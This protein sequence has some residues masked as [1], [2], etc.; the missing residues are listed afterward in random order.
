MDRGAVEVDD[1]RKGIL[2][3]AFE[4]VIHR[5]VAR[6]AAQR[7]DATAIITAGR[8]ISYAT[9]DAAADAYA[10]E[11]AERGVGPDTVVPLLLPRSAQLIALELGIL[12]CGA[13]YAGL[14]LRWPADR[15]AAIIDLLSPPLV[16]AAEGA[17]HNLGA[18]PVHPVAEEDVADAAARAR[19]F[20]ATAPRSSAPATVFF[21]SGT[22]GRPKIVVS[23][24]QAVS[25]MFRPDGLAGFGPGHATPQAAPLPWDMYAFEVWGQLVS[26]GTTVLV[27][28]DHLMPHTLREL[29][30]TA[31][32]D[33]LWITTS[34]FNLFV[35][36][37]PGC[38]AG[39]RQVLSGGEKLSPAHVRAFLQRHPDIPL[40]NGYGPAE[41]CMLT[42]TRLLRPEDCDLPGGV[43][44]GTAVPGTTV[45]VLDQDNRPCPAGQPGEI[46]IAG[47]G[48]ARGYFGDPELTA[49]KFPDI[50]VDGAPVRVYRT[51]DIGVTDESGVLHFRGRADRQMKISGHRV[52]L[53]EIEGA[54]H[55][56]SGVRACVAI[57]VPTSQG[58]VRSIAL[59][60]TTD[61]A[62][63]PGDDGDDPLALRDRLTRQLPGYMVPGAV[64]RVEAFP[65]TANGKVDS[66][67]LLRLAKSAGR[68]SRA[69]AR[70]PSPVRGGPAGSPWLPFGAAPD[71]GIR[72]LCLPHAGA[73]ATVYRSWGA[74][75]LDGVAVCPVQP[76]GRERRRHETALTSATELAGLLA[77]EVLQHVRPPYA[78]FGHST[79]ALV[80]FEL[81]REIRSAGGPAP[82]HLFVSGRPAP[83]LPLRRTGLSGL[84]T[85]ELAALLRKLGGTPEEVLNDEGLLARIHPLLTADF[86]VNEEYAYRP[87]EPLPAPIT[88]F[89][90]TRDAGTP[91][92]QAAAWEVQAGSGFRLHT[93][94]GGHFAVFDRATEVHEQIA[95]SL[96]GQS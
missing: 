3:A 12:K 73:G 1:G 96:R 46:C 25:R 20:T 6:H 47:Q 85:A 61:A 67:A 37:D 62:P 86:Q 30:S 9:L 91:L 42:T 5:A 49:A 28:E 60:Y 71:A 21:T 70:K 36:E 92:D 14:D 35:D 76:P 78:I 63:P 43:P 72:L 95:K 8:R 33:T 39:L 10:A 31:G 79:G 29:V 59:C 52:E 81:F 22:T 54:A 34:L 19:G 64:L 55:Q 45:L 82:V 75:A 24:H 44:V 53:A 66:A 50:Q 16:V 41:N 77:A 40:R 13:A 51:G 56:V 80:A 94:E 84:S 23:P 65:V 89:G 87:E 4:P 17:S 74:D 7:P 57:P 32:V 48:L 68:P 88:V 27:K 38:F 90:A 18:H 69:R 83:Q 15:I 93:L 26:G 11:L 58:E 2:T